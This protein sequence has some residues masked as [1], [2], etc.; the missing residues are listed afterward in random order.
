MNLLDWILVLLIAFSSIYGLFKGL[1]KEVISILAVIIGLVG[2]SR[3]YDG[4]SLLVKNL[5]L[6]EQAGRILS[7]IFLFIIISIAVVLIGKLLHQFVHAIFLGGLNRLGGIGFGF[8][9]GIIISG[10]IILIL[11]ITLSEKAPI[12]TESKLTPQ[13]MKISMV[14]LSFVPE[15]LQGR[16]MVQEKKLRDFWERKFKT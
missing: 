14:L 2:A 15:D 16:F 9:R 6:G 13:I 8:V 4:A 3:F 7:F 5:G 1:I 10:I 11:T 12:L